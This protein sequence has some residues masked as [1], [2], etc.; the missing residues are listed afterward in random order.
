MLGPLVV[1][2]MAVSCCFAHSC[3][4]PSTPAAPAGVSFESEAYPRPDGTLWLGGGNAMVSAPSHAK[5]VS[6]LPS[7]ADNLKARGS[8]A[9]ATYL[10]S[11][12]N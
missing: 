3:P 10:A 11:T 1:V 9:C 2:C 5:D 4:L 12:D 8:T 6:M 7:A